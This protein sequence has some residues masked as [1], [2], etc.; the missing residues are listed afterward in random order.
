M[1]ETLSPDEPMSSFKLADA[2]KQ[3]AARLAAVLDLLA[4]RPAVQTLKSWALSALQPAPGE[5]A[6]DVG[7]GTGEDLAEFAKRV[8]PAGRVVGVEPSAG[9]RTEAL[10][11]VS[12]VEVV[13]GDAVALSFEDE[14][15]DLI[16]CERVLQ[17]LTD[18]QQAVAEMARVLRPGGRIAL[19]DTDWATAIVHPVDPDVFRRLVEHFTAEAANPYS[20]RT[21]RGLLAATGLTI[22]GETAA[23]WIEPQEG[24]NEGFVPMIGRVATA[25]G[26]ITPTE[27][28]TFQAQI[29]EAATRGAFHMSLTMYAVAAVKL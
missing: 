7:S 14:S 9:L 13:D 20:G 8:G 3:D 18:P 10:K 22:T 26:A 4:T 12:G 25:A 11:R 19:I 2:D 28:A 17:H 5:A 1:A 15:F 23:T 24:A 27:G 21:L 29:T 16:R 6:L